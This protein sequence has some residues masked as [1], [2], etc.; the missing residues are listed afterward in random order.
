MQ[1]RRVASLVVALTLMSGF[2]TTLR[3]VAQSQ[4]TQNDIW[5]D[6]PKG[7]QR[8][9]SNEQIDR[10][11]KGIQQRDPTKAQ[12]L[13]ELRQQDPHRF[14]TELRTVGRPEMDQMFRERYEAHRQERNTKFLEWLKTNYPA[15]DQALAKLK[16][17]DPQFY[18][19]SFENVWDRY[20]YIFEAEN[21]SPELGAVL[22]EDLELKKKCEELC[23][24]H[25]NEK[26]D[27][28]KQE[29]GAS[30]QDVVARRYDLI[31]RKKEIIYSQLLSRLA[32]LQKQITDSKDDI[33]KFKDVQIKQENVRQRVETLIGSK[34]QFKW[35]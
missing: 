16:E 10:V 8:S 20:G 31:V 1:L 3:A 26:S 34:S 33:A 32:E 2:M 14:L 21:S 28:K 17:M 7:W 9:L 5:K 35:D 13:S 11:L 25:R 23:A 27:A 4:Q 12:E 22:K 24:Q 18:L 15:E 29:I 30:L 6:E 19:T